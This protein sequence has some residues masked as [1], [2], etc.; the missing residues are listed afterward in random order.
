MPRR[1]AQLE[2]PR[3]SGWGGKR[4]RA[5]RK[6]TGDRAR[7]PH[8]T[9]PPHVGRHPVHAT[10]R[11]CADLGSLRE[12]APFNALEAAIRTAQRTD[13]RI[14]HFSVQ[15]DH[16]HLIVEAS[17]RHALRRGLHGFAIRSAKAL[18]RALGHRGRVWGDRYHARA[19][20][21]P[22]ETR[23]AIVYVIQNWRKSVP[24]A[25][26]L[27]PCASGYWFDGWRGP[28]PRWA[29]PPDEPPP[30]RVAK[31]WLLK[32]GWRRCGLVAFDERPRGAVD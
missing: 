11:A 29:L 19:L 16:L 6:R 30:T 23:N 28:R 22:R 13:F 31:T 32:E 5:G 10:L 12:G 7:V 21:T 18:N 24:G 3:T 14:V 2:L 15:G 8:V 27:D 9:R 1:L 20:R 25:Q 4:P 17:D 26:C